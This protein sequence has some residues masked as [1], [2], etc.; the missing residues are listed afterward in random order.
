MVL[1]LFGVAERRVMRLSPH[2]IGLLI[3]HKRALKVI[4]LSEFAWGAVL[5]DDACLHEAVRPEHAGRLLAAAFA[6]ADRRRPQP[7]LFFTWEA[8]N[9]AATLRSGTLGCRWPFFTADA[10]MR[11]APTR[12]LS[13][14]STHP[15]SLPTSSAARTAA[16]PAAAKNASFYRA[17][18]I[19][20]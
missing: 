1:D 3:S 19:G 7:P 14:A 20:R 6:A 10:A 15:P 2:E 12:T 18:W 13:H 4:A 11:T 16:A 8:V 17:L 9:R 5:E